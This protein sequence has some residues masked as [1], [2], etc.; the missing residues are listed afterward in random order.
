[1]GIKINGSE[2]NSIH[3]AFWNAL[4]KN[5]DSLAL[6]QLWLCGINKD[7]LNEIV[8][9]VYIEL[10]KFEEPIWKET[11]VIGAGS[12]ALDDANWNSVFPARSAPSIY[13]WTQSASFLGDG[14]DVSRVGSSQSG[15]IKGLISEGRKDFNTTNITFLE[16]NISFVDGV[17]RPWAALVGHRSLKDRTLRCDIEVFCLEKWSLYW[18]LKI[19]KSIVYKNAVPVNIDVEE[20]NY[21]GDKLIQRQVEFAFD[22]YE[23]KIYSGS[24]NGSITAKDLEGLLNGSL[25]PEEQEQDTEPSGLDIKPSNPSIDKAPSGLDIK[26]NKPSGVT[27]SKDNKSILDVAEDI[28]GAAAGGL[29]QIQGA[30]DNITSSAAQALNAFG[31]NKKAQ[32][33][34]KMNRQINEALNPIG[35]VVSTGQGAINATQHLGSTISG[36]FGGNKVDANEIAEVLRNK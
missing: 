32:R 9:E 5:S 8:G 23:M 12:A 4:T 1:M 33:L 18:P 19:R 20:Y 36:T 2:N 7:K 13:L 27:G 15:S 34:A 22:R 35:Q 29:A 21:T 14:L 25:I 11:D 6:S 31:L 10:P 17:L 30:A 24:V 26:A 16:S 28:L 3:S